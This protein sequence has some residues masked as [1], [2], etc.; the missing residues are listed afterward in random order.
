MSFAKDAVS[1]LIESDQ[2]KEYVATAVKST[3]PALAFSLS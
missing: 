1:S 3:V 2:T